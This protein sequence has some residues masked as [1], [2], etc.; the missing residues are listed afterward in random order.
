MGTWGHWQENPILDDVTGEKRGTNRTKRL[1]GGFLKSRKF[2]YEKYPLNP[3][4]EVEIDRPYMDV[5]GIKY[6]PYPP[7]FHQK[8]EY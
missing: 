4:F 1:F 7:E 3:Y 6:A 8:K 2:L 5:T